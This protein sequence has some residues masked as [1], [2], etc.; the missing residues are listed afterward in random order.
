[1]GRNGRRGEERDQWRSREPKRGG[2]G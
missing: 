2:D 1:M